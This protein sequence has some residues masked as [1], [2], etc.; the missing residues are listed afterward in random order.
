MPEFDNEKFTFPDEQ[1]LKKGG[2][3]EEEID[4][5]IED[6][7]PA[8]DK[9]RQPMPKELVQELE[10]D[11]LKLLWWASLFGALGGFCAASVGPEG[12]ESIKQMTLKTTKIVIDQHT[13]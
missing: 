3:V 5:E 2:A 7:T 11:E 12:L 13:N 1:E 4:F 10:N 6:D 9:N 8:E